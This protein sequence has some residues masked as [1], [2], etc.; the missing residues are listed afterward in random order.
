MVS[1]GW[2]GWSVG[3]AGTPPVSGGVAT[4][5]HRLMAGNP[6]GFI[7]LE[8]LPHVTNTQLNRWLMAGNPPDFI[9][10]EALRYVTKAAQF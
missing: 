5:N 3:W 1:V 6:P 4:L 8:A 2:L 9:M 7:M 10:L